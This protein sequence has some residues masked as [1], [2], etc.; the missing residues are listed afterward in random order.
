MIDVHG[1]PTPA[2]DAYFRRQDA[3]MVMRA[4]ESGV[5]TQQELFTQ[6]EQ[7]ILGASLGIDDEDVVARLHDF[8]LR[9]ETAWLLGWVPAVEVACQ[10]GI[11]E[12]ERTCLH[13]LIAKV[14]T[15]API[16]A[17]V[18]S[19]CLAPP[20]L[21][22]SA[23]LGLRLRMAGMSMTEREQLRERVLTACDT[24]GR[25]SGGVLGFGAVSTEELQCID[26]IRADLARVA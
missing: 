15:D 9:A 14:A 7:K 26:A 8:G 23:R 24:V 1:S 19:W 25:A 5:R 10:N 6:D 17:L 21:F 2:E 22:E 18:N 16:A 20:G 3:E 11:D 13:D 4:R 12:A